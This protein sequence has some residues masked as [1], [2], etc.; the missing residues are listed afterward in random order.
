MTQYSYTLVQIF[1]H[2]QQCTGYQFKLLKFPSVDKLLCFN[3]IINDW[4]S[5]I[6]VF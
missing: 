3:G 6:V 5:L 1:T 2:N 4:N